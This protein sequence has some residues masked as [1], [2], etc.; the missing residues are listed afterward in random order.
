MSRRITLPAALCLSLA[1][2]VA[3]ACAFLPHPGLQEDEL[4]FAPPLYPPHHAAYRWTWFGWPVPVMLM[5]YVGAFKSWLFRPLLSM[6][7]P[8]AW[9]IRLPAVILGA[10]AIWCYSTFARQISGGAAALALAAILAADPIFLLTTTFDWGPVAMQHFLAAAALCLVLRFDRTSSLAALG[11]ASFLMGLALW[12]KAVF[13]WTLAALAVAAILL[14]PGRIRSHLSVRVLAVAVL[15]FALGSA[16]LIAYNAQHDL[17]TF[18]GNVSYESGGILSK[19]PHLRVCLNGSGMFGY[20]VPLRAAETA[21][22][23]SGWTERAA[24]AVAAL[25]RHGEHSVFNAILLSSILVPLPLLHRATRRAALFAVLVTLVMW[26]QMSSNAN[27]GRGVH[28]MVLL[29]PWPHLY[30]AIFLARLDT[31]RYGRPLVVAALAAL[32]LSNVGVNAEYFSRLVQSGGGPAWTNATTTLARQI[33]ALPPEQDIVVVD[34]GLYNRLVVARKSAYHVIQGY[35]AL[36]QPVS[37][38]TIAEWRVLASNPS[39]RF[40]GFTRGNQI[41]A[42]TYE[43]LETLAQAAGFRKR[44]L[45]TIHVRGDRPVLEIFRLEPVSAATRPRGS[46]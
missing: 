32:L 45:T 3:L 10:A 46:E 23:G 15:C 1:L 2:Y 21:P 12:N 40:A 41:F 5:S 8:S 44:V 11:W 29:W 39:K 20:F 24:S 34:W 13:V 6:F 33:A 14:V 27:T 30:A 42:G 4:L 37:E 17:A 31:F 43:T 26:I 19:L 18:R 28:H 22:P 38:R 16:P 9:T 25:A 36:R 7:E 35:D